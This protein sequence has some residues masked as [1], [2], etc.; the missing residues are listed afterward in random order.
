MIRQLN[1]FDVEPAICEF[2]VMKANVKKGNGRVTYTD[3][4][5]Q[6][7]RNA[8]GTDELPRTT[9]QDDRYD[10]FEQYVMAIWR[11]QRAVDRFFSWDTAEELCKAARDKKET[12][13]V[14]I[15]LGSGFKPDVVEYMR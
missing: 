12:I 14:R 7:P 1:I 4:R 13:P 11:F 3:V 5:V 9:K 8:K 15:Y 10:I 2:D 6:V